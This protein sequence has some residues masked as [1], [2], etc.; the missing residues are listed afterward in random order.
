MDF[1]TN[2]PKTLRHSL[3]ITAGS[4]RCQVTISAE[5]HR[6]WLLQ[7]ALSKLNTPK[8]CLA[9]LQSTAKSSRAG[10]SAQIDGGKPGFAEG[11]KLVYDPVHKQ[12][13]S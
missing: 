11:D 12:I 5:A 8:P 7:C 1:P 13:Y 6:Q 10:T 4:I 2:T 3:K 9:S